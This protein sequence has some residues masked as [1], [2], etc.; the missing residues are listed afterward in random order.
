MYGDQFKNSKNP[1]FNLGAFL[2]FLKQ[3]AKL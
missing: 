3:N 2:V 1:N